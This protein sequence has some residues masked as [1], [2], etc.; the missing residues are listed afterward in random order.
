MSFIFLSKNITKIFLDRKKDIINSFNE[1][2]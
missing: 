1:F 2:C